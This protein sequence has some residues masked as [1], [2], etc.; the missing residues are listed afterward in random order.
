MT[1]D[2]DDCVM[3][4]TTACDDCVVTFLLGHHPE[5]EV[6]DSE[7]TAISHLAEEGLVPPLRLVRSDGSGAER[8][9]G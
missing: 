3:Q 5:Q 6:D 7:L 8:R 4:A 9:A 1:I 2:C